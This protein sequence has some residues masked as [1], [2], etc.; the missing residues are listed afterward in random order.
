M[1]RA[2]SD[3][4]QDKPR[5]AVDPDSTPD[6]QP[7][8]EARVE[9]V[10]FSTDQ[11]LSAGRIAQLIGA[12]NAAEVRRCIEHLNERYD[13][14]G[15]AFRIEAIAK[16]F[17]MLTRPEFHPWVSKL[18]KSR[19]ESR[20]SGAALETLAVVAY[21]QPVLRAE[22]EAIRG[23][24]VG[25]MLVR[26]RE[27]NLVRIVGRADEIGRP[28]LYGTTNKFLEVFGL[29]SLKDLPKLDPEHPDKVPELK[30][31]EEGDESEST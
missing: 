2:V 27:M 28:L 3:T 5:A 7:P 19:A 10:L 15:S 4:V 1:I 21:K 24:A 8:R 9:A 22:I 14:Y 25:D 30:V 12:E 31:V 26:L 17:Q 23:V 29:G 20:L 6:A 16:G 11:P 13:T 18:H